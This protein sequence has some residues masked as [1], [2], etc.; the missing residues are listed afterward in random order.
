MTMGITVDQ[1]L[2]VPTELVHTR[3]VVQMVSQGM[4][5]HVQVIL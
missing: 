4:V 2:S 3:A 5:L 1:I